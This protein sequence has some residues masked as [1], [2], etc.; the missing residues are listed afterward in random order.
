MQLTERDIEIIHH[1][2]RHRFLRSTHICQLIEGSQQSILRRLQ[3]LYHHGYL[4]RPRVQIKYYSKHHNQP[5]VYSI[6]RKGAEL[7]KAHR[8]IPKEK[9]DWMLSKRA[10]AQFLE[11]TLEVADFMI[12][13]E[14]DWIKECNATLIRQEDL[15]TRSKSP[16]RWKA[17]LRHKTETFTHHIE[18]DGLFALKFPNKPR[19]EIGVILELDRG[20]MPV[21]RKS[22]HHSSI[23]RKLLAY[24]TLWKQGFFKRTYRWKRVRVLCVVTGRQPQKRI[25]TIRSKA[26]HSMDFPNLVTLNSSDTF[27]HN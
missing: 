10:K 5:L 21:T 4:E 8:N 17:R 1:V 16:T 15:E 12:H 23:L 11:H 25:N 7:L 26:I 27:P 3:A 9:I 14:T 22:L 19:E 6:A 13:L 24:E 20:T 2:F 18:P